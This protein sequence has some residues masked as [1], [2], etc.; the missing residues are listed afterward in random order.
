MPTARHPSA[1]PDRAFALCH[2]MANF[3]RL[4][5]GHPRPHSGWRGH[6]HRTRRSTLEPLRLLRDVGDIADAIISQLGRAEAAV[7][8]TVEIEATAG[9]GFPEDVRRAVDENAF[10]LKFDVH[11]FEDGEDRHAE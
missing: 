4:V 6:G 11:E 8:I 3:G 2:M 10:T 9:E 1:G 7:R 5:V